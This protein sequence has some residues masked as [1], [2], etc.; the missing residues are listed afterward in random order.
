MLTGHFYMHSLLKNL[1]LIKRLHSITLLTL[2]LLSS[3]V[4]ANNTFSLET[5]RGAKVNVIAQ[6]PDKKELT[7]AKAFPVVI[8]A[9]GSRYHMRQPLQEKTAA[10][11]QE[12]G[13]AVIRF[14]WAYYVA[15]PQTGTQSNDRK[16]EI[17]DLNRVL[18][19]VRE[20]KNIDPQRIIIAGKSLGSIIGWHVFR[21]HKDISAAVLLTPVCNDDG[22]KKRSADSIYPGVA[23]EKRP[24]LWLIGD[25]DPVCSL[26]RFYRFAANSP[27][28]LHT[29]V[30]D[31]NHGFEGT[32]NTQET[33]ELAGQLVS[34]FA[35]STVVE[36]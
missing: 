1:I 8:L 3:F 35:K 2:F 23:E 26:S 18:A 5:E 12:N 24:S 21:Q 29:I 30:L 20:Q 15:D 13:F 22:D 17:E 27:E 10:A 7:E 33:L 14:D 9:S 32:P 19:W 31:G 25:R 6:Y 11:L 36:K 28:Q 34:Y 16:A 4:N